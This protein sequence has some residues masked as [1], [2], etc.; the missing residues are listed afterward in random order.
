[1]NGEQNTLVQLTTILVQ[2]M[3]IVNLV[4]NQVVIGVKILPNVQTQN[5][6]VTIYSKIQL[7][8]LL[9]TTKNVRIVPNVDVYFV[10][11]PTVAPNDLIQH[12]VI[13]MFHMTVIVLLNSN[14]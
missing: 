12:L 5:Q 2:K 14:N 6:I 11:I 7:F 3:T 13:I 9:A 1:L 10:L 8:V 4:E